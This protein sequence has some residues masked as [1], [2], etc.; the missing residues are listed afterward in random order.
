MNL[1]GKWRKLSTERC[2]ET[3]PEEVVFHPNGTY[4]GTQDPASPFHSLWDVGTY[5]VA[6]PDQV[7]IST[8]NDAKIVYRA[9]MS[10]DGVTFTDPSGC[11]FQYR[12]ET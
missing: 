11:R 1:V 12:R 3:Y 9:V 8:A 10:G 7:R 2:A 6:G 4:G 5:E